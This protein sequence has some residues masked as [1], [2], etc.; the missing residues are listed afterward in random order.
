[1]YLLVVL[2]NPEKNI[3]ETFFFVKKKSSDKHRSYF[4]IVFEDQLILGWWITEIFQTFW[5]K[6]VLNVIVIFSTAP[7]VI[8]IFTYNPFM[9]EFLIELSLHS[10]HDDLFPDKAINLNKYIIPISLFPEE[11]RVLYL[12]SFV[13]GIDGFMAVTLQEKMNAIF[14]ISKAPPD[15]KLYGE[16]LDNGTTTGSLGQVVREEC[17]ASFNTRLNEMEM[18]EKLVETSHTFG[19]DDICILVPSA[20]YRSQLDNIFR[21]FEGSVWFL[22]LGI[23][24]L[25]SFIWLEIEE[26]LN[27]FVFPHNQFKTLHILMNIFGAT[28]NQSVSRVTHLLPSRIIFALYLLYSFL[29]NNMYVANLTSN[30]VIQIPLPDI[31]NLDQLAESELTIV[32]PHTYVDIIKNNLDPTNPGHI[33]ISNRIIPDLTFDD[34]KNLLN[35]NDVRY[36]FADKMHV[37][38][39]NAKKRTHY[40]NGVPLLHEMSVCPVPYLAVYILTYGSPFKE[41]INIIVRRTLESGLMNYWDS[42]MET[43]TRLSGKSYAKSRKSDEDPTELSLDHMQAAFVIHACGNLLAIIIFWMEKIYYRHVDKV[44]KIELTNKLFEY[45]N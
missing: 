4:V 36:A 7:D 38:N 39:F 43:Q 37:T 26:F 1:M 22:V 16:V 14:N 3:D 6:K 20:G 13:R 24:F 10:T 45:K 17:E 9:D 29:L 11:V 21:G 5:L 18:F 30:I 44:Q 2:K 32:T 28:I 41:R 25:T 33:K 27:H 42:Y 19:R 12:G 35:E 8:K 15:D 31:N 23:I 40:K 34:V